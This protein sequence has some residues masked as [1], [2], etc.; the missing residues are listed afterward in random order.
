M[1]RQS[2]G[3]E[4]WH[5]LL[6]W[7]KEQAPS[8][9]LSAQILISD[10]F[11]SID[12]SHPL[13]GRDGL[14]DIICSKEGKRYITGC[15]FPRG[16]EKFNNIKTKFADDAKGLD[17][18]SADGFIFVTNQELRLSERDELISLIESKYEIKIYHLERIAALLNSPENYGI[19][20]E[21]LDIEM[22][23]EEQLSFMASKDKIILELLGYLKQQTKPVELDIKETS[24]PIEVLP[25]NIPP[26]SGH[27]FIRLGKPYHKC[28]YCNYGYKI[29]GGRLDNYSGASFSDRATSVEVFDINRI[30]TGSRIITCPK[31]GNTESYSLI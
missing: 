30:F 29:A 14:K 18:N 28:S 13:G 21:F 3:R 9:R 16:Q 19:R 7:D 12:P 4:T 11:E 15:F 1:A 26:T 23:K 17:K 8:E 20:L 5:R 25:E 27:G 10:K 24:D 22:T 2:D 6:N 31:C